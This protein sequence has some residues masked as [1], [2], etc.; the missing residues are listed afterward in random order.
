MGV[1]ACP[2]HLRAKPVT[3][4]DERS[5]FAVPATQHLPTHAVPRR[6]PILLSGRDVVGGA[7]FQRLFVPGVW[8]I[9]MLTRT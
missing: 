7:R 3:V 8:G 6:D 4:I 1:V 9:S 5:A 2:R